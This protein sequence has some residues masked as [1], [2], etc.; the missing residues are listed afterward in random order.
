MSGSSLQGTGLGAG[1]APGI[2]GGE[3]T[4]GTGGSPLLRSALAGIAGQLGMGVDEVQSS[5]KRGVSIGE[6]ADQRGISRT[7]LA[8]TLEQQIQ[9]T[10]QAGG[11]GPLDQTT[12]DRIV[13]RAFDRGRQAVAASPSPL[14]SY[15]ANRVSS[16]AAESPDQP[17]G[18][19]VYA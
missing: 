10:R 12:L 16:D 11:Q 4:A 6:L 14:S 5:L 15:S 7:A 3:P 8:S 18:F 13:G 2:G 17:G 1:I 19:S 9:Q